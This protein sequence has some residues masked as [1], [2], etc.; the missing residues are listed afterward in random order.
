MSR[1]G[2]LFAVI[3]IVTGLLFLWVGISILMNEDLLFGGLM[4]YLDL[5][6]GPMRFYRDFALPVIERHE[7]LLTHVVGFAS[8]AVGVLYVTGTLVSLT[9]LLAAFLVANFGLASSSM[10]RTR[11]VVFLLLT[12]LMLML[13]RVG[14]GLTWGVDG[15]LIRRFQDWLV[16]FPLRRKAP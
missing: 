12:L 6:G 14:A 15:R 16:L 3:R 9:S 8:I 1:P 5:T 10:N 11:E 13:G 7:T 2:R 4:R